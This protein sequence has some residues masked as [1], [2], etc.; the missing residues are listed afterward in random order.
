M[1]ISRHISVKLSSFT[2]FSSEIVEYI[3]RPHHEDQVKMKRKGFAIKGGVPVQWYAF[4]KR[5]YVP[6]GKPL[7]RRFTPGQMGSAFGD[8]RGEW[9]TRMG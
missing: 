4:H 5:R 2:P 6:F 9:L 8:K 7:R 3:P 1:H